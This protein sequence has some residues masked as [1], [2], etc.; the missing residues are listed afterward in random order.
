MKSLLR[1]TFRILFIGLML[2]G[3]S[4]SLNAQ[5][6]TYDDSWSEQGFKL[7]RS[8]RTG[9]EVMHSVES[10]N[11]IGVDVNGDMMSAVI[12]P[13]V[14][15]QNDEGA[16]NLPG[17][18]RMIAIP[19]GA[20][21]SLNI[22][23]M[24][25]EVM[26][27]MVIAP[28]PRI[29][30][31][32][33]D[34][35][36]HYE[37]NMRIYGRNGFY[38]ASPVML[39]EPMKIRGVDVVM[40]SVT[41]FQY[42]PVSGELKVIRDIELEVIF[43][44]GSGQFGDTRLRSR[45]WD[46]VMST[47]ILNHDVL[48]EM[49]YNI[50]RSGYAE[51]DAY[52]YVIITPD[53]DIYVE[54]ANTIKEFR[55]MQG[56][57]T[58]VVTLS[59]L[60][61]NSV[62]TIEA[63]IDNAYNNWDP[64]PSAFLLLG[65]YTQITSH[66]YSHP[67]GYPDFASDNQYADVDNDNLPDVVMARITANDADELE[68]M[69]SKF[70]D[71]ENNPPTDA[72][73]YNHPITAL[74][75]QTER[76]FQIC[77]EVVGGFFK[78]AQGK[79]PVRIN[80]IYSGS[81][82]TVW[83]TATN[84]NTVV[85]YFGPSGLGYIP[86]QPNEL[87]G[88]S[89]GS[90]TDVVN[91]INAGSFLLQH[92]DHGFYNGWGEPAF[93]TYHIGQLNNVDNKLPYVMSINC[94]TGAFHRYAESFAE[95]FHRHTYNGQNSGAL[96]VLAATEVSYS[97]VND[98][99][100]WGV[101]DN[102]F[103]DFMPDQ[104]ALFPARYLLPAFGNAAGKHF[105]FQSSWP[106]N[107]GDK[108][109]TYRLFHHHGDAFSTLYSEVPMNLT[110]AHDDVLLAG[111]NEFTVTADD[112]AFIALS[113]N[114]EII[115]TADG[116]GNPVSIVIEPQY[117]PDM[118]DIVVTKTNYFRYHQQVS[119]IPPA[120][121]YIIEDGQALND[122]AGNNNG[123][124][125][126]GESVLL[127]V[128]MKNVGTEAGENIEVSISTDD[129]YVSIT[130]G[131]ASYGAIPSGGSISVEDA[132]SFDVSGDIPDQHQVV[133]DVVATDGTNSWESSFVLEGHAPVLTFVEVAIDDAAG[134]NDGFLDPGETAELVI[135]LGNS[136]TGHAYEV[137]GELLSSDPYITINSEAVEYGQIAS[138]L[139]VSR[140]FSITTSVV[141]PAGHEAEFTIDAAA[142]GG[143]VMQ[144]AFTI[145]IGRMPVLIIDLDAAPQNSGPTMK[146]T[147]EGLG[148]G[149]EYT[150]QWP[151]NLGM[152]SNIFVCLG[153]YSNNHVLNSIEGQELA[154]YLEAGGNL[155]ME[156][157]DTWYYDSP[158]AVHPM[159]NIL[160]IADGSGDLD[161][162]NGQ[163]GT[164]TEGLSYNYGGENNYIDHITAIAPAFNIFENNN[165]AYFA[166]VA[167]DAGD[168]KAIGSAFEFGG[169][170]N[171]TSTKQELMYEY[172][173]FFGL[174]K[175]SQVP[176]TPEGEDDVCAASTETYT[177]TEVEAADF[178]YWAINPENAGTVNGTGI[179]VTISWASDYVGSAY[180]KVCG[181]NNTGIGPVS[182]SLMVNVNSAPSAEIS[183]N[184]LICPGVEA[185]LSV[186]LTG[187]APWE[188]VIGGESYT[189]QSSPFTL[190]VAPATT[191]TFTV[192]SVEDAGG[193]SNTGTGTALV[194]IAVVPDKP[195]VPSGPSNVN[196]DEE[197][198]STF[199][200]EAAANADAYEWMV[201]PAEA[202]TDM[203]AN[204]LEINVTWD[205]TYKGN[206]SIQVRGLNGCEGDYSDPL[207]VE[208]ES[209]YG[210]DEL[211]GAL[212]LAVYPN[213]NQGSFTL[214]LSTD[215]VDKVNLKVVNALGYSV[216]EESDVHV[217]TGFSKVI[218]I[219]SEANGIYMLIV[220]S[221]LGVYTNRLIIRK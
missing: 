98:V 161:V 148:Y 125:D 188:L 96:G 118:V 172:L 136:G 55:N 164:F 169:L 30:L 36:L 207:N 142:D 163:T 119:V 134:N 71:Y 165:P 217:N 187:T 59:E 7:V 89:G 93:E 61:G 126:G 176:G 151:D 73:F 45:W 91:A 144:D 145:S 100:V 57:H 139:E 124:I 50:Q 32:T 12:M 149:V 78:H 198:S 34:S 64:A 97:F 193:C 160:K 38:P 103:E 68:V 131:Q 156:G 13:G 138:T 104:T 183:G 192:E 112:G 109:V 211:A 87:G 25:T 108:L 28:A 105:L 137:I 146:S 191:T 114:G 185:T 150:Q 37:K 10:F 8:D 132:F 110:V 216:F 219:S 82:G 106:Y 205:N 9:V 72:D 204:D 15:L 80:E 31:E 128:E 81:P 49:N 86:Q 196:S 35:P 92:R 140:S 155:Y 209:S 173:N 75:W 213:P 210:I 99:F 1:H 85:S 40:L 20:T 23:S 43:E 180:V 202:Y 33:D 170:A 94:Q 56:I 101:M 54:W 115:G 122:E 58:G 6:F 70:L 83:S 168:Y 158:T 129:E 197:L 11:L 127:T 208:L 44:G 133:F 189:A 24:R 220:E 66:M 195:A 221:D 186:A 154:D 178:Y 175:V 76:W 102:M 27:G 201:S 199:T 52:E 190:S 153:I 26:Q 46:P 65:D 107:T 95:R 166:A 121:P 111:L 171:G 194:E 218:D 147:I 116:T 159:F 16:P 21:A 203:S 42:N 200:V 215:I 5:Q 130:A 214:E 184:A 29:P 88:W 51:S 117:P 47:S 41:P 63:Y 152:Y 157:G 60:G 167:Y 77:S 69:I 113:V 84:T 2:M 62:A 3:S 90:A 53:D 17:E 22:K 206:V 14:F 4:N 212:G 120:G 48:P 135:T 39:S 19:Q 74:G 123:M 179:E 18:S 174:Q 162:V 181:M 143:F 141:T 79:D 67:A 182:D 177:T